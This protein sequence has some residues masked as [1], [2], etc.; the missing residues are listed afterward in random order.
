MPTPKTGVRRGPKPF[1]GTRRNR[2]DLRVPPAQPILR[3]KTTYP[4]KRRIEVLLWLINYRVADTRKNDFGEPFP[5]R[6]KLGQQQLSYEEQR[7]MRLRRD[8][9][10]YRPP[11]YREAELFWKIRAGT[12]A[13][14]WQT[15]EKYLSPAQLEKA[16]D[17]KIQPSPYGGSYKPQP[18]QPPQPT[19]SQ[20]IAQSSIQHT[21]AH[22]TP[23]QPSQLQPGVVQ[24]QIPV[25]EIS[26]DSESDSADFDSDDDEDLLD[27]ESAVADVGGVQDQPQPQPQPQVQPLPPPQQ[28]EQEQ[29]QEKPQVTQESPQ[30]DESDEDAEGFED[31][32]LFG[33]I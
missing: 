22:I 24:P 1:P 31:P 6:V 19:Q 32:E 23:P 33:S 5:P 11:T 8:P 29:Q 28:Q 20:T 9:V 2:C 3:S 21:S 17:Y 15:R 4:R 7:E 14:W 10:V 13:H 16:R 27:V 30:S 25:V 26:D 12:I 18:P